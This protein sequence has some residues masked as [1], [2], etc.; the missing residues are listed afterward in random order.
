MYCILSVFTNSSSNKDKIKFTVT[1]NKYEKFYVCI[2]QTIYEGTAGDAGIEITPK[3]GTTG[4]TPIRVQ[5][6]IKDSDKW[7]SKV[8]AVNFQN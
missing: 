8:I 6:R 2:G 5:A 4:P 1:G 3:A 7:V